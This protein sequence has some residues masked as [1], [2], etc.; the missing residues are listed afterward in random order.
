M[1][2]KI[3]NMP[4]QIVPKSPLGRPGDPPVIDLVFGVVFLSILGGFGGPFG[5]PFGS[6][7]GVIFRHFFENAL[8]ATSG[9]LWV[10]LGAILTPCWLHFGSILG[11]P[12][13][14]EN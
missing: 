14:S 10:D 2:Q 1:H 11:V 6:G 7:S 5:L 8:G 4:P 3:T 12:S 9:R 13:K